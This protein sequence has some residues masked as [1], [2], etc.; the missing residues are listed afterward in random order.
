MRNPGYDAYMIRNQS[1]FDRT[2]EQERGEALAHMTAADSIAIG[3]ALL[4][5]DIMRMAVFPDD[6]HPRSL[7]HSL[8]IESAA[9]R[10]HAA[11]DHAR[12]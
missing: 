9:A 3:E 5:S 12:E 7:A 2:S 4:T 8:G 6:D 1:V 10:K 11:C